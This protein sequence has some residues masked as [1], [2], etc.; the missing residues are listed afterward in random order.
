[1]D[2]VDAS[3]E[4]VNAVAGPSSITQDAIIFLPP[5]MSMF[6]PLTTGLT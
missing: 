3:Y 2:G 4:H 1:M 5:P 6:L